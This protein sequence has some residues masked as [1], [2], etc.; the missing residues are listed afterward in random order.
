MDYRCPICRADLGHR[1]LSQAIVA[2]M[3]MACS[4]CQGRIRLNVHRAEMVVVMFNF[5]AIVVMGALAYGFQSQ[6]L[7]LVALAA[8]MAGMA[9][10]PLLERT[11]LRSWPRYTASVRSPGH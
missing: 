11:Y 1:K 6:A 4:R 8:A 7:V 10:L 3:E 9:A 5:G 2:R